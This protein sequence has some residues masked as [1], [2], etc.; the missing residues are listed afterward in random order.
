M[1]I[2]ATD[3]SGTEVQISVHVG[4]SHWQCKQEVTCLESLDQ[5]SRQQSQEMAVLALYLLFYVT[6]LMHV[7]SLR[8]NR[9][10][11]LTLL[12]SIITKCNI[13]CYIFYLHSQPCIWLKITLL[14]ALALTSLHTLLHRL[15][16]VLLLFWNLLHIYS[17]RVTRTALKRGLYT[18][19][20]TCRLIYQSIHNG[21]SD[22]QQAASTVAWIS[23]QYLQHT[24]MHN[25]DSHEAILHFI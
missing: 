7:W 16:T 14:V 18:Y 22:I 24:Q 13:T 6:V 8:N 15:F 4:Y 25:L 1:I 23:V 5:Q 19:S 20:W 12:K 3:I 21:P 10:L 9:S 17:H 2:Y 11:D